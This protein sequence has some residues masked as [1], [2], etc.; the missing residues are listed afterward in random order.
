MMLFAARQESGP[1]VRRE[2]AA[3]P[4]GCETHPATAPAASK[5]SSYGGNDVVEAFE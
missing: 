2:K 5:R 4:S 1:G 3:L